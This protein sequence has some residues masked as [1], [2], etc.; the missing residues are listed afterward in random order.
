MIYHWLEL[1]LSW[2]KECVISETSLM[3]RIPPNSH[4]N[5]PVQEVAAI[6][7]TNATFQKNN[8]KLCSSCH[9]VSCH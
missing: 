8:A 2:S 4:A 6:Q 9:F 7:K 3:P 5:L 1:D